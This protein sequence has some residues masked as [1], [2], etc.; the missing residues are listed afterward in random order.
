MRGERS[1]LSLQRSDERA[2]VLAVWQNSVL[3]VVKPTAD[4]SI[5]RTSRPSKVRSTAS[6][7]SAGPEVSMHLVADL[8]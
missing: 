4:L 1:V 7:L 5:P 6:A 2:A 8:L 3:I